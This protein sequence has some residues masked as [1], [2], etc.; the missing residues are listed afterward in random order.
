MTRHF[1]NP[2]YRV[3]PTETGW[4]LLDGN[5]EIGML[6]PDVFGRFPDVFSEVVDRRCVSFVCPK[7]HD[8]YRR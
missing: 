2:R 3:V 8:Y 1:E 7:E 4:I 5:L 6:T